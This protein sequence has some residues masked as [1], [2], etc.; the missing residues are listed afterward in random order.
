MAQTQAH[1][2][3]GAAPIEISLNNGAKWQG[4]Q[5]MIKGMATIRENLAANLHAIHGGVLAKEA[6][7]VLASGIQNEVDYMVE[8]CVLSPEADEQFH[9][10]L[11]GVIEGISALEDG[12]TEAGAAQI[13]QTLNVYGEHFDHPGW[14]SLD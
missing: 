5:H 9:V 14:Q 7:G 8:S 6:V 10:I 12:E 13:V 4:D 2:S 11:G 1:D 3:H